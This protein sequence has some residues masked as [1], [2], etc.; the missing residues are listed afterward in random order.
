MP[1]LTKEKLVPI[2]GRLIMMSFSMVV[3]LIA[4]E[5]FMRIGFDAL[6]PNVQG[7]LQSVRR[8]PW[9]E[10][11]MVQGVPIENSKTYQSQIEPGLVDFPVRWNDARFTFSTQSIWDGHWIGLRNKGETQWPLDIV[12]FGDSF[13]FCWTAYEDCWVQKLNTDYG[14]HVINAGQPGNGSGGQL[15]LMQELLEPLQP[16]VVI[17]QWYTNDISDEYVFG[18]LKEERASLEMPPAAPPIPDAKGFAQYS[19]I[20]RLIDIN[21]LNPPDT[22]DYDYAQVVEVNGQ[23]LNIVSGEYAHPQS[24]EWPSIEEGWNEHVQ[25]RTAGAEHVV[26][27]CERDENPLCINMVMVFI[28]SKEEVYAEA[29]IEAGALD[30]EYIETIGESRRRM[31]DLCAEQ[32]WHCVDATPALQAAVADGQAVYYAKD[33]H[34]NAEGN[35]VVTDLL[36]DYLVE[37]D[38]L[39]TN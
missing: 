2:L 35:Q 20:Y 22:G 31:L 3:T 33:F 14:W 24:F 32:G 23:Q 12:T 6:P 10:E 21:L 30:A 38:L 27:L 7:D 26:A 15:V 25:A 9:N 36:A 16:K 19:A 18:W 13:T 37:Q 39:P 5:T 29:I 11:V 4:I 1:F 17:W 28:P 8:V 34:L